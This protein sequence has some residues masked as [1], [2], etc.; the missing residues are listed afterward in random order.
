[1]RQGRQGESRCVRVS[2]V[3]VR[4]VM[5]GEVLQV[6]LRLGI[7]RYGRRGKSSWV[8]MGCVKV[9]CVKAGEVSLGLVSLIEARQAWLVESW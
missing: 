6:A 3:W 4:C 9:C 5:A 7:L 2:L 1:M 8:M